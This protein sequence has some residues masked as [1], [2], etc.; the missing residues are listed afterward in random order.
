MEKSESHVRGQKRWVKNLIVRAV[1]AGGE[2][3]SGTVPLRFPVAELHLGVSSGRS[4]LS[5]HLWE[6]TDSRGS[7]PHLSLS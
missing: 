7:S 6:R 2:L 3:H 4:D 5:L 1:L